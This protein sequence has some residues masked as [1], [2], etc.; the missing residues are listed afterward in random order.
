MAV[1]G[2]LSKVHVGGNGLGLSKKALRRVFLSEQLERRKE[3]LLR[4]GVVPEP[5][6]EEGRSIKDMVAEMNR[7]RVDTQLYKKA[8][9][10]Q[11]RACEKRLQI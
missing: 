8:R 1:R 4:T 5:I 3:E 7:V 2:K 10:E 6:A 9:V 11:T